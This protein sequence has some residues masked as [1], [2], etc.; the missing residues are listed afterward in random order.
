MLINYPI[1][2]DHFFPVAAPSSAE[3]QVV[4]KV[5]YYFFSRTSLII[6]GGD[7]HPTQIVD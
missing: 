4:N 7:N 1:I 2:N 3:G 5:A 6:P